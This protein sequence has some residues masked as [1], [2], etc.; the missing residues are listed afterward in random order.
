M[1]LAFP[2]LLPEDSR[3]VV[4]AADELEANKRTARVVVDELVERLLDAMPDDPL[5]FVW[6]EVYANDAALK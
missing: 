3:N 1:L 5:A 6:S 2:A 4:Q